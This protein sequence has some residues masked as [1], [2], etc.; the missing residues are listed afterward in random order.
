MTADDKLARLAGLL[1][2][3]VVVTG[4][5]SL[6]YVPGRLSGHGDPH[7]TLM[8]ITAHRTLFAAGILGFVLEQVLFLPLPLLL[9]QLLRPAGGHAAWLMVALAVVS[10]P[11]AL[12]AVVHRLDVLG[13]L[14]QPGPS[15]LLAMAQREAAVMLAL[16]SYGHGLLVASLF[17]GLWLLPFGYLVLRCGWLPRALGVLLLLGGLGY[18]V[19]VVASVMVPAY[20]DAGWAAYVTLPAALGEIGAALW[21]LLVGLRRP[22]VA[23]AAMTPGRARG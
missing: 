12:V 19:D 15:P 2:L 17:W 13:M 11:V 3:L 6:A 16:A 5:F 18:V 20:A 22:P 21:L 10:V 14:L 1:Y 9:F 23:M 8:H 4:F 7:A